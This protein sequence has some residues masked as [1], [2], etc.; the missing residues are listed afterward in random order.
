MKRT[1]L[2]L[3]EDQELMSQGIRVLLE[4][5]HSIVGIVRGGALVLA[6]VREHQ[7]DVVLLDLDLPRQS[8]SQILA[9]LV[10]AH[11]TLP[12][13]VVTMHVEPIVADHALR[14]GARGFVTKASSVEE[15]RLAIR[16]AIQGRCFRTD[17]R[18]RSG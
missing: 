14:L 5:E 7:P 17:E 6:G 12:V 3:V 16:E 10:E 15:L 2:L 1:R 8:S 13:V 11:P 4:P 9:E 18:S